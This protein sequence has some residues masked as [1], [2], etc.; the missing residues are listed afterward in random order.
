MSRRRRSGE[1]PPESSSIRCREVEL[2]RLASLQPAT[3]RL[4]KDFGY[5]VRNQ[6]RRL[7][8]SLRNRARW[9]SPP[10]ATADI[11]AVFIRPVPALLLS[12]SPLRLP[13]REQRDGCQ[14][15]Q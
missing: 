9:G 6:M 8:P 3:R 13:V 1:R 5:K 12:S 7:A 11:L 15:Q 14:A 2:V 10:A 4:G